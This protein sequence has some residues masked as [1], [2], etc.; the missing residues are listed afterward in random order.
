VRVVF[1][2]VH[3]SILGGNKMERERHTLLS[4][5]R[6]TKTNVHLNWL[7]AP[8]ARQLTREEDDTWRHGI[9]CRGG[10]ITCDNGG[11]THRKR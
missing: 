1:C 10:E 3:N 4:E 9:A 8:M 7:R 6:I 2:T 11:I 5:E